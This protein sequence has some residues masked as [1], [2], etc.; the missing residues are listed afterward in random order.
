M[1]IISP[2]EVSVTL[3]ALYYS[4]LCLHS[5]LNPTQSSLIKH[6]Q[7]CDMMPAAALVTNAN[8]C[9]A[10]VAA[11]LKAIFRNVHQLVAAPKLNAYGFS[12][13]NDWQYILWRHLA[14]CAQVHAFVL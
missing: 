14:S 5:Y 13:D 7:Q 6:E 12:S 8:F 3:K 11:A 2:R 1:T 10:L 4:T 9:R